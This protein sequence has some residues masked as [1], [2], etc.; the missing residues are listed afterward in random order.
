MTRT[1]SPPES[2]ARAVATALDPFAPLDAWHLRA[3]AA[4][5][6]LRELLPAIEGGGITPAV[7]ASAAAVVDFLSTTAHAHHAD[8]ERQVFPTLLASGDA[9]LEHAV[10]RLQQ[11]HGWLEENWRELEPQLKAIAT[12]CGW[13]D[14]DVLRAA[15]DVLAALYDDHIALE[16]SLA[17]PAARARLAREPRGTHPRRTP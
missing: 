3:L 15:I 5:A 14:I 12:G 10:R 7:R 11:D 16:E 4:V 13:W 6:Q 17:Y 8:E 1:A 2:V 9:D